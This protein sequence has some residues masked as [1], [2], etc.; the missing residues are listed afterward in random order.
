MDKYDCGGS[1][2][3]FYKV[4]FYYQLININKYMRYILI[5][6]GIIYIGI[7]CRFYNK[8]NFAIEIIK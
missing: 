2:A 6:I 1:R 4:H 5:G 3:A 8:I 7:I